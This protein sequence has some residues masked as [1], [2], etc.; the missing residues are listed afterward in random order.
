MAHGTFFFASCPL[1]FALS[2]DA[3]AFW[4][5]DTG[6]WILDTG[7]WILEGSLI[8]ISKSE[9]GSP[10]DRK[11]KKK[12]AKEILLPRVRL[13][14]P[15]LLDV[16]LRFSDM[17]RVHGGKFVGHDLQR[18]YVDLSGLWGAAR[19]RKSMMGMA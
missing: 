8:I 14:G 5:L 17:F 16:S 9:N 1:P 2:R 13:G 15:L 4:M 11:I 12:K 7:Y 6:Y 18:H 10:G 19:V 3:V